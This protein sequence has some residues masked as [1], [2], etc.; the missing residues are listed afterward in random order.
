MY[1]RQYIK[2]Q[3]DI[4]ERSTTRR[5]S[6]KTPIYSDQVDEVRVGSNV[7]WIW[8][9]RL[10]A[11]WVYMQYLE[12]QDLFFVLGTEYKSFLICRVTW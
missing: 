11:H 10:Q 8:R 9:V 4:E 12:V 3:G 7:F 5:L 6:D 2:N 1:N